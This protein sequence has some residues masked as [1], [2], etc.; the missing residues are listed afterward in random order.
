VKALGG[1]MV[2]CGV[3]LQYRFVEQTGDAAIIGR[4]GS[5][6]KELNNDEEVTKS[7]GANNDTS[8]SGAKKSGLIRG[9]IL[10]IRQI[11]SELRKVVTPTKDELIEYTIV[12]LVF[13]LVIM[14]FIT[15][16]DFGIGKAIMALF[17]K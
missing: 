12:V 1:A 13:V 4:K 10:F 7:G 15:I 6:S 17:A 8:E 2:C 11:I 3:D 5:M 14:I 9:V 16:V